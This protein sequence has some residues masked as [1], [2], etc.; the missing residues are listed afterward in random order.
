MSSSSS[1]TL[2]SFHLHAFEKHHHQ[3]SVSQHQIHFGKQQKEDGATVLMLRNRP[4]LL[5][6]DNLERMKRWRFAVKV[7]LSAFDSAT[8]R[9]IVTVE[10]D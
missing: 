1:F 9:W 2:D 10:T 5:H 6:R 7:Q 3:Q 8:R 4:K